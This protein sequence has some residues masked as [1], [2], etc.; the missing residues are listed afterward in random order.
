[1]PAKHKC[2]IVWHRTTEYVSERASTT[3]NELGGPQ[4]GQTILI[5]LPGEFV[6]TNVKKQ[7][8]QTSS[9]KF[10]FVHPLFIRQ[11]ER[12][13]IFLSTYWFTIFEKFTYFQW[14][15]VHYI[16]LYPLSA[17]S[18]QN[19]ARTRWEWVLPSSGSVY[20][21]KCFELCWINNTMLHSMYLPI[22][23]QAPA[24]KMA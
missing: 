16:L 4:L 20:F 15:P 17:L 5:K 10:K 6:Q 7:Q 12:L 18:F 8:Q 21:D 23:A 19:I 3:H 11:G 1:M 13:G 9:V 14:L 24:G 22:S 2:W